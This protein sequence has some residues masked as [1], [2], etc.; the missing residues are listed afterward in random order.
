[1]QE[2]W[3]TSFGLGLLLSAVNSAIAA[4]D[5]TVELYQTYCHACHTNAGANVPVAFDEKEWRA[6]LKPGLE[7]LVNNAINGKGNMPP[8]G[9]C[10]E[11]TY[12]D[13]EDLINYMANA[14]NR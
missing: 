7:S 11:C 9:S 5:Y 1:V 3:L 2:I 13:F 6:R 10:M 8:Q 12:E 14:S 4:D